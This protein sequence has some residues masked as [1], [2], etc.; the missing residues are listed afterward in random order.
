MDVIERRPA[1]GVGL[2]AS[3]QRTHL[4]NYTTRMYGTRTY[5]TRT[6]GAKVSIA[7]DQTQDGV[8][9]QVLCVGACVRGGLRDLRFLFGSEV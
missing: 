8:F 1:F 3:A 9:H 5:G 4:G 7:L 6:Y 2:D